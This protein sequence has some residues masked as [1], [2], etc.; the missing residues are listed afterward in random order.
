MKC[1]DP[2][3]VGHSAG[4]QAALYLRAHEASAVDAVVSL[5]TTQDYCT[6]ATHGWEDL[7]KYLLDHVPNMDGSVLMAANSHAIFQ[8]ADAMV[9]ADRYYLL[10]QALHHNDFIVQGILAKALASQASPTDRSARSTYLQAREQYEAVCSRVL[11]F[12]DAQLGEGGGR[13]DELARVC[14]NPPA[15]ATRPYLIHV[16]KGVAGAEPF[17]PDSQEPP[18]PRQIRG[19]MARAGVL[20]ALEILKTYHKSRP[21]APVFHG[22]VGYAMVDEFIEQGRV[23]D[24]TAVYRAYRAF[25]PKESRQY[26]RWGRALE[27]MGRSSRAIEEYRKAV[28]I[29]PD[30]REAREHL[31]R[32]L[33]TTPPASG[34]SP[35]PR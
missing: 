3:L 32:L 10:T 26:Y 33:K 19:L 11:I 35:K 1:N 6:L 23:A 18:T 28:L 30:D 21:A 27:K 15:D 14:A 17:R 8:F 4:A 22:D 16:P 9:S 31:E 7:V 29:D 34:D 20:P 12:L 24:A 25:D 5:D 13:R 2:G